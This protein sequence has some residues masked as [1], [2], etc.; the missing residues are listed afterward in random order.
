MTGIPSCSPL[1]EL[2]SILSWVSGARSRGKELESL[3]SQ[4]HT[5]HLSMLMVLIVFLF[6]LLS[7]F[8]SPTPYHKVTAV[9]LN[10]SATDCW[11]PSFTSSTQHP[12]TAIL[13]SI[14][15][16]ESQQGIT[17]L[18]CFS[19]QWKWSKICQD[20]ENSQFS[21]YSSDK[22]LSL[23]FFLLET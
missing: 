6:P 16:L 2:C 15:C 11:E 13:T 4:L 1:Y 7:F 8:C 9:A 3:Q 19:E 18:W 22:F 12:V 10:S 21:V 5:L 17:F 23:T 20:T 14:I